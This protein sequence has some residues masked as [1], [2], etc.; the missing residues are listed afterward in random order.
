MISPDKTSELIGRL[1]QVAYDA[2]DKELTKI[3]K[4]VG[5]DSAYFDLELSINLKL[6]GADFSP[7]QKLS[8]TRKVGGT[9]N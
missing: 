4:K 6:L 8:I 3:L 1:H 5:E 9:D 7:L 2:A